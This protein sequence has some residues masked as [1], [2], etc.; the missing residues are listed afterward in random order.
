MIENSA[1]ILYLAVG[2]LLLV[3]ALTSY[4]A[5][6]EKFHRFYEVENIASEEIGWIS[7]VSQESDESQQI[8][9]PQ[10]H[11]DELLVSGRALKQLL[12]GMI[13]H[14]VEKEAIAQNSQ[15]TFTQLED[16]VNFGGFNEMDMKVYVDH[17]RLD[18]ES[19]MDILDQIE[20]DHEYL[21]R[22]DMSNTCYYI[23]Y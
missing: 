4:F 1:K 7:E 14:E 13:I 15:T 5:Q 16:Y 22:F 18:Q 11:Q 2:V 19:G 9:S 17:S 23:V 20:L 10:L 21:V 3:A 12:I 8:L 6:E